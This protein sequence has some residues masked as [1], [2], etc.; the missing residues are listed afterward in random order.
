MAEECEVDKKP[1]LVMAFK[2]TGVCSD[3]CRKARGGETTGPYLLFDP[4]NMDRALAS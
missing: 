1:I 4:K 2:G 3:L